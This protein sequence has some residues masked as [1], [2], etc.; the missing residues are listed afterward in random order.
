[1]A[2]A[3]GMERLAHELVASYEARVSSVEQI[4]ASTHEMLDAFR[5]QREEMRS[6]LREGLATTASLRKRD[7]DAMMHGFQSLQDERQEQVK[8]MLR[9]YLAEQRTSARALK[10]AVAAGD[11]NKIEDVAALLRA[12]GAKQEERAQQIKGI[13]AEFRRQQERLASALGQL[14]SNGASIRVADLKAALRAIQPSHLSVKE[15][16]RVSRRR[17]S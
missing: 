10:E 8:A 15:T 6:R 4:I 5:G 11:T 12:F 1:M 13:L 17:V 7:F 14:L 9:G 16:L 2:G 3:D